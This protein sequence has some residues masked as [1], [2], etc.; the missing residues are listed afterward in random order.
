MPYPGGP[1][2]GF[3]LL[4]GWFNRCARECPDCKIYNSM[5]NLATATSGCAPVFL[6][7][8]LDV[9]RLVLRFVAFRLPRILP[10]WRY[11]EMPQ[12]NSQ[13]QTDD[14]RREMRFPRHPGNNRQYAPDERAVKEADQQRCRNRNR[15]NLECSSADYSWKCAYRW[16]S[17]AAFDSPPPFKRRARLFLGAG[18]FANV[19][20][21]RQAARPNRPARGL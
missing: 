1:R 14:G 20:S 3:F 10:A 12:R 18:L 4:C 6:L 9:D 2:P 13:H 19:R 5:R 7:P 17:A 16:S 21:G 11:V 15:S 8:V